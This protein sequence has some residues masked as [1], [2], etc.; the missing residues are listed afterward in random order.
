MAVN[1]MQR[2]QVSV[3][4]SAMTTLIQTRCVA[5]VEEAA[6]LFK[7]HVPTAMEKQEIAQETTVHGTKITHRHVVPLMTMTSLPIPCAAFARTKL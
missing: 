3:A 7:H 5:L 1:G 2:T 6:V 4:L